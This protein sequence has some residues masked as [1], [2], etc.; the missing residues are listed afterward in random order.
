MSY[1]GWKSRNPDD[2]DPYSKPEEAGETEKCG[3][4]A[5]TDLSSVVIVV[6]LGV[7]KKDRPSVD[8]EAVTGKVGKLV[9]ELNESAGVPL[10]VA[11]T[12]IIVFD[13]F[14]MDAHI[15][16]ARFAA[17]GAARS[18]VTEGETTQT[19]ITPEQSDREHRAF[20]EMMKLTVPEK[21][22]EN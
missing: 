19:N 2:E 3:P 12:G 10:V 8:V 9:D 22:K 15:E 13:Q 6:V 20:V 5:S 18:I 17:Q 7:H 21:G 1:D 11:G 16:G 4:I 14:N